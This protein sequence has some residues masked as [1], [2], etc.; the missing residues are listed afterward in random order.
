MKHGAQASPLMPE[1]PDFSSAC[2]SLMLPNVKLAQGMITQF[3]AQASNACPDV[4][5]DHVNP[6]PVLQCLCKD[7]HRRCTPSTCS[8]TSMTGMASKRVKSSP[9]FFSCWRRQVSLDDA[10]VF[11]RP[12]T[13]SAL[14]LYSQP[15]KRQREEKKKKKK[16]MMKMKMK[17]IKMKKKK[18]EKKK[19]NNKKKKKRERERESYLL[20]VGGLVLEIS[21]WSVPWYV[22]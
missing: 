14:I 1:L 8:P 20:L 11:C 13:S 17:N 9:R 7:M 16:M 19:N 10:G 22:V 4:C 6:Y 18:K 3:I 21:R 12:L 2:F 15:G 5:N